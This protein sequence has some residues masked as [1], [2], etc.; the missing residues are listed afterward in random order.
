MDFEDMEKKIVKNRIHAA[1]ILFS[2]QPVRPRVGALG[3]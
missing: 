1:V 2:A 3:D